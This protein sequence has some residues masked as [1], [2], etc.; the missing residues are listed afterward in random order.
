M[1]EDPSALNDNPE[2]KW[3]GS[4]AR[5]TRIQVIVDT[6][7]NK[8]HTLIRHT[9][10]DHRRDC[11]RS[12]DSHLEVAT[13]I[14]EAKFKLFTGLPWSQ[15]T[16][17]PKSKKAIFIQFENK[18]D[19]SHEDLPLAVCDSLKKLVNLDNLRLVEASL[20]DRQLSPLLQKRATS[21]KHSVQT[22]SALLRRIPEVQSQP[23]NDNCDVQHLETRLIECFL[24]LF[25][26]AGKLT[27]TGNAWISG[28]RKSIDGLLEF[29]LIEEKLKKFGKLTAPL[30][31]HIYALLDL[32]KMSPGMPFLDSPR[33]LLEF[34]DKYV[35][36]T[37]CRV[38]SEKR[39]S[40]VPGA[41]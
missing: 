26:P 35:Y 21:T 39:H 10:L 16:D 11:S 19:E 9:S 40:W 13:A 28:S 36:Y 24:G 5:I 38:N 27:P 4:F 29:R 20:V 18:A 17:P 15:R 34:V 31:R 2:K 3:R 37:D 12:E 8:Y 7:K 6:E 30:L 1:V 14:F 33:V 25:W 32:T 22:A 23:Q 41:C